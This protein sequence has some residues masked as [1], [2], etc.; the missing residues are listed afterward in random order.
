[1]RLQHLL[2]SWGAKPPLPPTGTFD[3]NTR[4]ALMDFQASNG[5]EVTGIVGPKTWAKLE[6]FQP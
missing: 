5:Q 2:N 6:D 3:E 4:K 1:V